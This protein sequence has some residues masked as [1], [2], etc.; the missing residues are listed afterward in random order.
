M[1]QVNDISSADL[2]NGYYLNPI[3][4]G[5]YSDP[6][7]I[8]VGEDYYMT[9]MSGKST[10]G[11]LIWHSRDLVNWEMVC[12][13]THTEIGVD[14]WAPD[15]VYY[16]GIYYIYYVTGEGVLWVVTAENI[17]GPW[18]EPIRMMAVPEVLIDPVHFADEDGNRFIFLSDGFLLPIEANGISTKGE[19]IK[20]YEGWKFPGEWV[21]E[22]FCL[23]S[24]KVFFKEGYYHLTVAQG[25]TFGPATSHMIVS[26][27]SKSPYGPWENS[28]YNPILRN[29]SRQNK[30]WS[31]GHGALVDTPDGRWYML[32]HAVLKDYATLGRQLLM[33]PVEWTEDGWYKI[34]D[35]VEIDQPIEKPY[36]DSSPYVLSLSDDFRGSSLRPVWTFYS[37][38]DKR[39]VSLDDQ[40]LTLG[41]MGKTVN[42]SN[43]LVTYTVDT[44]YEAEVELEISGGSEGGLLLYYNPNCFC[45]VGIRNGKIRTYKWTIESN[46][47]IEDNINGDCNH[48]FFRMVNDHH[49]VTFY[50]SLDGTSWKKLPETVETS[51]YHHNSFGEFTSLKFCLFAAGRGDVRYDHFN[52]KK[53]TGEQI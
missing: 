17:E 39:S 37:I 47:D 12:R 32:F 52:Y 46:V 6:A 35:G 18:H 36:P 44:A 16:Q 25:G 30:W 5:N 11:L 15:I 31:V 53:I 41:G 51:G 19:M 24:N 22:G 20:V 28:P 1:K 26:A 2:G 50:Y 4:K 14:I 34:P 3:L 9:N 21:V 38:Y 45:G 40:G 23:E 43:K 33:M 48:I 8:R 27:R 29:E 10:P 49:N 42:D 7:V 13:A